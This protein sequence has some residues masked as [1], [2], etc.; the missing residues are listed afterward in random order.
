MAA[1][2]GVLRIVNIYAPSGT[3]QK[4]FE[5]RFK[6]HHNEKETPSYNGK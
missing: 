2:L 1:N 4:Q 6:H 3:A 5:G